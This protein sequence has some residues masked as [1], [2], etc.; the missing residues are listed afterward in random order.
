M[1]IVCLLSRFRNRQKS[2]LSRNPQLCYFY[3]IFLAFS[4]STNTKNKLPLKIAPKTSD[5]AKSATVLA[6]SRTVCGIHNQIIM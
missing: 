4:D 5:F 6:E 2:D 3:L 1:S